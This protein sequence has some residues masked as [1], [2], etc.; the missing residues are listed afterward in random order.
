MA[1]QTVA[2]TARQL[3][4]APSVVYRL[5]ARG[6]IPATRVGRLLRFDPDALRRWVAQGGNPPRRRTSP[7]RNEARA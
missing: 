3:G 1:L 4:V 6:A 2:E 5:A 7:R